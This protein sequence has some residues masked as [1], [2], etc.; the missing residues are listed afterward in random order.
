VTLHHAPATIRATVLGVGLRLRTAPQL[1][2]PR[3]VDRGTLAMLEA[4]DFA[5]GDKVLDLGCGYGVVG[6][7]AAKLIGAENVVMVDI[8]PLAVQLARENAA[9]NG[10]GEARAVQSDGFA[11]LDDTDFSIILCNPP[12]H[13]NFSV[14]KRFIH[15]GFNRLRL[16]GRMLMVTQR[17]LWYQN[18]FRA[19]FGGSQITAGGG[20]YV[21][22]AIKR[23]ATYA[24][25]RK[26]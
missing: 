21:F 3:H 22:K 8:D 23:S 1:F 18:K 5:A 9:A 2:S 24:H 16:G 6:I 20:Y 10:V 17:K 26:G 7:V 15:K 12:Y 19:I 11:A 25:T 14:P 13:V 4:A